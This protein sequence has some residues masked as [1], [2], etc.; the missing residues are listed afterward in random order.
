MKKNIKSLGS[1]QSE[2]AIDATGMITGNLQTQQKE[3]A[4]KLTRLEATKQENWSSLRD[5]ITRQTQ[6]LQSQ[7]DRIT[8]NLQSDKKN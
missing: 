8:E 4:D 6:L 1:I 5:S 3:I 7:T 2:S